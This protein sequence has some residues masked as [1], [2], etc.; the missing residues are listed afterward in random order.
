MNPTFCLQEFIA[1]FERQPADVAVANGRISVHRDRTSIYDVL[2]SD[3]HCER[4]ILEGVV[5]LFERTRV[6]VA[7][8]RSF[9][10]HAHGHLRGAATPWHRPPTSRS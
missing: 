1:L 8:I 4:E 7:S 10:H 6:D 2:L 9:I 5:H 3:I